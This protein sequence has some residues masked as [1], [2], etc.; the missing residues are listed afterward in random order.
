VGEVIGAYRAQDERE[1]D[2]EVGNV[3]CIMRHEGEWHG[4]HKQGEDKVGWVPS[5]CLKLQARNRDS[6][7][8]IGET[9]GDSSVDLTFSNPETPIGGV[10]NS[11]ASLA[12]TAGCSC[13]GKA[14][15]YQHNTSSMANV[16]T[17][18]AEKITKQTVEL[19]DVQQQQK[20]RDAYMETVLEIIEEQIEVER[21]KKR[22]ALSECEILRGKIQ[23]ADK[24]RS[25]AEK[26]QEYVAAQIKDR[27]AR[28]QRSIA[29]KTTFGNVKPNGTQ[30]LPSYSINMLDNILQTPRPRLRAG[31][32]PGG[33]CSTKLLLDIPTGNLEHDEVNFGMS[34]L[35]SISQKTKTS[36]PPCQK[37]GASGNP[38]ITPKRKY[39]GRGAATD[40]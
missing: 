14:R 31:T 10:P 33:S 40:P 19:A 1:L 26:E 27:S 7:H 6:T 30:R 9:D 32:V 24:A 8:S 20:V 38:F 2:V 11:K 39:R 5:A 22:E 29:G 35:C 23:M 4:G 17:V 34:P 3:L 28:L 37:S 21:G 18:M 12:T 15:F 16:A 13:E 25:E 36:T